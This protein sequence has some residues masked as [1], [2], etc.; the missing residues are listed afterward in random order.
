MNIKD[1]IVDADNRFNKVFLLFDS[2]S[3]EFSSG[4]RLIDIFPSHFS[5]HSINRKSKESVKTQIHKLDE[6]TLQVSVDSK[7]VIVVSDA[8]IK[9]KLLLQYCMS[10]FMTV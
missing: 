10:T 2:F 9:N 8:S 7:T 3:S 1:P 5:F 4:D 6:I